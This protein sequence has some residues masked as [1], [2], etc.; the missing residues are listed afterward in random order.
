MEISIFHFGTLCCTGLF[1]GLPICYPQHPH[2]IVRKATLRCDDVCLIARAWAR[3]TCFGLWGDLFFLLSWRLWN[4]DVGV[5]GLPCFLF[6]S[7]RRVSHAKFEAF[8][9]SRDSWCLTQETLSWDDIGILQLHP[10]VLYHWGGAKNGEDSPVNMP[11]HQ[12][13]FISCNFWD[14]DRWQHQ[15]TAEVLMA[16]FGN[17]DFNA[18]WLGLGDSGSGW[19]PI[20]WN[21]IGVGMASSF[22]KVFLGKK[23][24]EAPSTHPSRLRSV[25]PSVGRLGQCTHPLPVSIL[26][27]TEVV[28]LSEV[29]GSQ[30]LRV[31]ATKAPQMLCR[32]FFCWKGTLPPK[33]RQTFS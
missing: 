16:Q 4:W 1:K 6:C 25:G 26:P 22:G 14:V 27:T 17:W 33:K 32:W 29:L 20:Y 23:T 8:V 10:G 5:G 28:G 9:V 30:T 13:M 7:F 31:M 12:A 19:K 21:S 18:P 2:L 15:E 3:N 11:V 24:K